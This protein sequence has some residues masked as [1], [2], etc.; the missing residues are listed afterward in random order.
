MSNQN[1]SLGNS[2]D[3]FLNTFN[4]TSF[5]LTEG[6]IIERLK[7]EFC[8]FLNKDILPSGLIYEEKCSEGTFDRNPSKCI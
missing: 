5:L 6:A 7:R 8:I 1:N 4:N 2:Q 3:S